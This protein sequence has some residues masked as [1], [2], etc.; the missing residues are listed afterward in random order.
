LLGRSA[1]SFQEHGN[2]IFDWLRRVAALRAV[3]LRRSDLQH[4]FLFAI[5]GSP[6][7]DQLDADPGAQCL[8][9]ES[10]AVALEVLPKATG[11]MH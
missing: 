4:A 3:A 2:F 8:A 6:D 7:A 5:R 10:C 11:D 9:N 1:A